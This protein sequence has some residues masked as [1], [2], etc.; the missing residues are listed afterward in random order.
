MTKKKR[1]NQQ[2]M[3][4]NNRV[5][6]HEAI[7]VRLVTRISLLWQHLAL[8]AGRLDKK[9]KSVI[10]PSAVR[11]LQWWYLSQAP[12]RQIAV[13][14]TRC[15]WAHRFKKATFIIITVD[16]LQA[17]SAD[18]GEGSR[19]VNNIKDS[20]VMGWNRA[21]R[22]CTYDCCS[23]TVLVLS[24]FALVH[25]NRSSN[26]AAINK[27]PNTGLLQKVPPVWGVSDGVSKDW[28]LLDAWGE[29]WSTVQVFSPHYHFNALVSSYS[30]VTSL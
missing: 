18:P 29:I 25:N 2:G 9:K 1:V 12:K 11:P 17:L 14:H 16:E 30:T 15:I 7:S 6:L 3:C 13:H 5:E 28:C 24:P 4:W 21:H 22:A 8:S 20:S 26:A 23:F 10:F 27:W 19:R